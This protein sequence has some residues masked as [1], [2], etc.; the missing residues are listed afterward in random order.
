MSEFWIGFSAGFVFAGISLV[1]GYL[2][3]VR[4]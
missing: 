1:I 2:I 4:R 3:G